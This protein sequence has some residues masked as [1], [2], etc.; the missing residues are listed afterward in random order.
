MYSVDSL[1][2]RIRKGDVIVALRVSIDIGRSQLETALGNG[3]YDLLYIDGQHV[4]FS[5]DQLVALCATAEELD[6]PVQFRIPH[7][8]HTYLIGRYLDLGL[9]AILVPEVTDEATVEEAIAYCYYPQVGRRS[10]GGTARCGLKARGGQLERLEYAAWW[11]NYAVLAIQFESVEAISNARKL[12]KPGVDYVAFGPN[13]LHFSLEGH[14]KYPLQ[15]VIDCM[16]NVAEQL[17]DSEI[18]LGMAVVTVPEERDKYLEMGITLF[19]EA[20]NL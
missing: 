16:R 12:V 2:Q 15:T 10:W 19:Q 1:K 14:P 8:R 17:K 6:L 11:N 3:S 13:D 7:T 5:D 9:T 20:P 18:R 4:A